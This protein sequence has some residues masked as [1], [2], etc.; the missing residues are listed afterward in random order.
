M[1]KTRHGRGK[2]CAKAK[3]DKF[4]IKIYNIRDF[5]TQKPFNKSLWIFKAL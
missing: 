5:I 1:I 3:A 2:A 4:Q